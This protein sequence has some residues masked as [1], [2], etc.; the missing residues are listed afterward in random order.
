M[1]VCDGILRARYRDSLGHL[2]LL[3]ADRPYR[4]EVDLGATAQV[5][6]A[7]HRVR[8][9]V[10]SSDFP[11]YDRNLNTGGIFGEEAEGRVAANSV[12]HDAARPSHIIFPVL[13]RVPA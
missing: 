1:S 11:R 8:G 5:F 6:A 2:T 3:E 12:F 13:E 4:F 9:E 7:G 10:T